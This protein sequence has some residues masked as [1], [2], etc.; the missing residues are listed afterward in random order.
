MKDIEKKG[1][2]TL[3]TLRHVLEEDL[4]F[5]WD[6]L[7]AA[8]AI[9]PG[10][11]SLGKEKALL[12]PANRKYLEKWGRAGDTGIIALNQA[13]Q[14]LGAAWYRCYPAE[15]ASYGFVSPTIPELTIG[16]RSD[17]RHQGIGTAL[18]QAV[19]AMARRSGYLAVSLSVARKNPARLL[20]E[21]FGFHDAG[22]SRQE[23]TSVTMIVE[24]EE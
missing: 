8:A 13:E 6:M 24:L 22:S 3:F 19:L 5:L 4:P 23:D 18:L 11:R 12:L 7:Y 14:P 2:T 16:V 17:A 15:A 20:Y 9:D 10:M 1:G 21:R